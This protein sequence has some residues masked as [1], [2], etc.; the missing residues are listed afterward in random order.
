MLSDRFIPMLDDFTSTND[1]I[2]DYRTGLRLLEDV[3]DD[4]EVLVP[5]HGSVCKA[6]QVHARIDQDRAY[7]QALR[8]RRTP[9]DPRIGPSAEPG[10]EWVSDI[11]TGHARSLA[12][13]RDHDRTP[14]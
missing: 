7:L 5:G 4:V 9:D 10:W 3:A 12:R 8:D 6:D 2:E 14:E 11:H 13:Q 1:P